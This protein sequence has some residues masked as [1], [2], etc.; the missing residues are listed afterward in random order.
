MKKLWEKDKTKLDPVIEAFETKEDLLMDQKL[1]KYDCLGS[2]AHAKM[3]CKI[4]I[5]SKSELAKLEKGLLEILSLDK[6]GKFLLKIGDED[7][8]TKIENFLTEKYGEVGKKIH[9]GKSRN[10]QVLAAIRLFNKFP[11]MKKRYW[12]CHFWARGY[13]VDTVGRNEEVIRE[14]IKNQ[15]KLDRQTMQ[16][17][18]W[19]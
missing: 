19:H 14:Y 6:Q 10:D 11:E 7:M 12:G 18:L 16:L 1:V 5:L 15:D 4:G 9:T 3:L 17:K 13:Y 8:H 2:L